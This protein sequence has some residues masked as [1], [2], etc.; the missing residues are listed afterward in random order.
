MLEV[1]TAGRAYETERGVVIKT[2]RPP[3]ENLSDEV[4]VLWQDRRARSLDQIRKAWALMGEIA[5]FQ[6]QDK[7][8]VYREQQ[9][10]FSAKSLGLLQESLFHLSTATVS[11]AR[12][13]I[14]LLIEIVVEYGIP[15]K[16]PLVE[17]CEDVSKY[18]Y[19]CM[20]HKRCAVCGHPADLHH[21]STVGMGRDRKQINH[22]GLE[23]LPL[24]RDH[25]SE[26]HTIGG[27]AFLNR[28]HLIPI[29]IDERIA[30][31]YGLKVA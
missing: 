5:E 12:A 25:H 19:A 18:V 26:Y 4:Q 15:T 6:G 22:L 8:D 30:K 21:V 3:V 1:V 24:C 2:T 7:E 31:K 23:A 17:M 14:D 27:T 10:A 9:I 28:Y 20:M 13:F 29:K 11:E 16:Q